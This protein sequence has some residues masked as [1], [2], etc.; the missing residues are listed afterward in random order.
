MM[1]KQF[2]VFCKTPT[3]LMIYLVLASVVRES[4]RPAFIMQGKAEQIRSAP[5]SLNKSEPNRMTTI[6]KNR[7]AIM[8]S[9]LAFEDLAIYYECMFYS[10]LLVEDSIKNQEYFSPTVV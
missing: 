7:T 2:C 1:A 10:M 4:E 3:G 8:I 5:S 9:I 6:R